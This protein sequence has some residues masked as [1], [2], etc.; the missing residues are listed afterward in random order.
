MQE[1]AKIAGGPPSSQVRDEALQDLL[2]AF[3]FPVVVRLIDSIA[4]QPQGGVRIEASAN[5]CR[6]LSRK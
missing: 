6:K 3:L 4:W 5:I 2:H 1:V